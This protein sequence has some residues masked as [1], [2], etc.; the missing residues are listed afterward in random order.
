MTLTF[1]TSID[2]S[3]A[4]RVDAADDLLLVARTRTFAHETLKPRALLTDAEGV[5]AE[6]IEGLRGIG[7]LNHLAPARFGGGELDK[8]AE[9]R[10]H[11]HLAYGDFNTWLAWAQHTGL[12]EHFSALAKSGK[13]IGDLGERILRG[14][15]LSG[16]AISDAR[17]YPARYVRATPAD[18]GWTINGTVSWVSGWGVNAV[19]SVAAIDPTTETQLLAL[20]DVADERLNA[21]PLPLTAATGSRTWRVTF[22][23]VFV[24][25]SDI[26]KRTPRSEWD[27]RDQKIVSDVRPQVFGVARAIL[28]ELRDADTDATHAVVQAWAPPFAR[29]RALAYD[30]ADR[31]E[32]DPR[33][34]QYFPERLALK[35]ETLRALHKISRAL[36]ISRAG[37]GILSTDTAQLHA[38]SVLF[39]QIQSQNRHSRTAQLADIA[40]SAPI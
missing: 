19:L 27:V 8:A 3:S 31:A 11:E 33:G 10:V 35:V 22:D 36:L 17:H 7:L 32:L 28:D 40:E 25:E 20:I 37:T 34:P 4:D 26:V 18:G 6:T 16:T 13:P 2:T 39:L 30:L 15:I 12:L 1:D 5:T 38:R 23:D 9:R 21:E 29:Y 14:E 24:S